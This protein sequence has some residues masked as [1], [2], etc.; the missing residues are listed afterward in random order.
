MSAASRKKADSGK[1]TDAG[2]QAS[3]LEP[4]LQS[5]ESIIQRMEREEQPLEQSLEDFET[6]IRL[7]RQAQA[8]LREAEQKVQQLLEDDAGNPVATAPDSAQS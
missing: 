1:G 2:A 7:T 4:I 5:I 3:S 8:L 6:G